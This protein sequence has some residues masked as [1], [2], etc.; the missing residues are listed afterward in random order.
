MGIVLEWSELLPRMAALPYIVRCVREVP[1][2][3]LVPGDVV[4][5]HPGTEEPVTAH[6]RDGSWRRLPPNYGAIAGALAED[7]LAMLIPRLPPSLAAQAIR[8]HAPRRGSR[9]GG[10]ARGSGQLTLLP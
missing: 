4:V 8:R 10:G 2:L 3:E 7:Q 9:S 5:V 1:L 6:G